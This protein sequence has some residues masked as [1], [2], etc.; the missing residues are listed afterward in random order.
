MTRRLTVASAALLA[1]PVVA[2]WTPDAGAFTTAKRLCVS[3]ARTQ[4]KRAVSGARI[5]A[6]TAYQSQLRT[7]FSDPGG[8]CVDQCFSTQNSCLIGDPAHGHPGPKPQRDTCATV[9]DPNDGTDS[10]VEKADAAQAKCCLND[11]TQNTQ[12][13]TIPTTGNFNTDAAAQLACAENVRLQRFTC[14]QACAAQTQQDFDK[15]TS[16]FNDCLEGC[17]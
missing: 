15:C 16:Q 14:Q 11:G 6:Q 10:C 13:C 7:C 9:V 4:L 17:G 5:T 2:V 8:G 3:S 12:N 1:L